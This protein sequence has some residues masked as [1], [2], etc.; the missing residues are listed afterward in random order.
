MPIPPPSPA[1]E[2]AADASVPPEGSPGVGR[3]RGS[4]GAKRNP[5][6]AAAILKAAEE[7]LVGEGYAGF[8][9]EAVARRAGAGKPTIYRWWPDKTSLLIEVYARQKVDVEAPD[10]GSLA[11]D[12]TAFLDGLARFWRDTVAGRAFRSIVA[13]A[14]ADPSDLR[15]LEAFTAR[16]RSGIEGVFARAGR[17]GEIAADADIAALAELVAGYAWIRL[18]TGRLDADPTRTAAIVRILLAG[19][20]ATGADPGAPAGSGRGPTDGDG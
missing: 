5:A 17:R 9:V 19:A 1:P 20:G 7:I 3:R 13:E 15:V 2:G 4:I 11:G 12:L 18:L 8:T 14:Q 6:S 16:R 10:T